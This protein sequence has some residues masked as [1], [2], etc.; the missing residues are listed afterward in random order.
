MYGRRYMSWYCFLHRF[1]GTLVEEVPLYPPLLPPPLPLPPL[2]PLSRVLDRHYYCL[3]HCH[4]CY[5]DIHCQILMIE[6]SQRM[7]ASGV[8]ELQ[9]KELTAPRGERST[10]WVRILRLQTLPRR[11]HNC[12]HDPLNMINLVNLSPCARQYP[13]WL[14]AEQHDKWTK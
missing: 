11:G 14:F 6:M 10:A 1:L 3:H 2:F 7:S 8:Q 13:Q 12:V 4:S 5:H 9:D